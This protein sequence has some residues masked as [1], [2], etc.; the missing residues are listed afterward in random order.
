ARVS[1]W[2]QLCHSIALL[3]AAAVDHPF[4]L[5]VSV[6]GSR[7]E[8]SRLWTDSF[9]FVFPHS[10][11]FGAVACCAT[12]TKSRP[13]ASSDDH[14]FRSLESLVYVEVRMMEAEQ[15]NHQE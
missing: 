9:S 2:S 13:H 7:G 6:A 10:L 3:D 15:A 1:G 5:Y 14:S 8:I 12:I 4:M 11:D